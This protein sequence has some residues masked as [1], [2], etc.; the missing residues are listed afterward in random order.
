MG[1]SGWAYFT[2]NDDT[3]DNEY[4]QA[5]VDYMYA[6]LD[7]GSW[8]GEFN[9]SGKAIYNGKTKTFEG[10]DYYGEDEYTVLDTNIT[11]KVPK[12]LWFDTL[13]IEIEASYDE[14]PNMSVQFI[15]KNGF[16]SQ[17]HLNICSNLEEVLKREFESIIDAYNPSDGSEFRGITDIWS[18]ERS[19]ATE[20]D[21]MLIFTI[22]K[23]DINILT[24]EEKS[25]VLELT[26]DMINTIDENLNQ[27]ENAD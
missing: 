19:K 25:V 21:E 6:V 18:L 16:L 26:D 15:I 10:T 4:T 13:N 23:L 9:S 1:D 14:T 24:N 2:I 27:E 7:Y 3:V 22:E 5:V 11:V 8:A 20:E 17:E 12:K